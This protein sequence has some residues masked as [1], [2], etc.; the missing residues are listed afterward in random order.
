MAMSSSYE[1]IASN[2]NRFTDYKKIRI[3]AT[4]F[5]QNKKRKNGNAITEIKNFCLIQILRFED[6]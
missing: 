3:S 2:K 4:K 1:M 5:K 6:S